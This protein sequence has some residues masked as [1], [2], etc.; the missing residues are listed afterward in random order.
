MVAL[1]SWSVA[2]GLRV[3]K[4]VVDGR[5]REGLLDGTMRDGLMDGLWDGLCDKL[6]DAKMLDGLKDE[7]M[8][9]LSDDVA[10][11]SWTGRILSTTSL[12]TV[13]MGR[14]LK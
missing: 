2:D 11:A 5:M 1:D 6:L 13:C 8:D 7:E 10:G 3:G 9:G 14:D 12:T 4:G